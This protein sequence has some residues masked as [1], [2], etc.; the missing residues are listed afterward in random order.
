MRPDWRGCGVAKNAGV[1]T[2]ASLNFARM[3][4]ADKPL[5]RAL[6]TASA[7][8]IAALCREGRLSADDCALAL[9]LWEWSALRFSSHAQDRMY[10]WAGMA[11]IQRRIER[12]RR[13]RE[14]VIA[15]RFSYCA[16]EAAQGRGRIR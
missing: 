16:M 14:A 15:K 2:R 3:R 11:G 9:K 5:Y 13:L 6:T 7:K 10:W 1:M 12:C 8:E 4:N